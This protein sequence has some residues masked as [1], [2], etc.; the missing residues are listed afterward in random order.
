MI[1][2][3]KSH[4]YESQSKTWSRFG[5]LYRLDFFARSVCRRISDAI[6]F[7]QKETAEI[8]ELIPSRYQ[9]LIVV[10]VVRPVEHKNLIT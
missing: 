6:L 2:G 8:R 4:G 7:A 1:E 10:R 3:K 9:I 5:I